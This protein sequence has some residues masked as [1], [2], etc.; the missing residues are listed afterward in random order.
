[1]TVVC[2]TKPCLSHCTGIRQGCDSGCGTTEMRPVANGSE[3]RGGVGWGGVGVRVI[4]TA[5]GWNEP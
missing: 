1:M 2:Y 4:P 5:G 3:G